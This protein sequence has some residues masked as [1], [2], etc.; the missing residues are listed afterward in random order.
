MNITEA[1][2]LFFGPHTW[3]YRAGTDECCMLI[4]VESLMSIFGKKMSLV[5]G[6]MLIVMRMVFK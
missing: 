3:L 5:M 6:Q 4:M 2:G 1:K